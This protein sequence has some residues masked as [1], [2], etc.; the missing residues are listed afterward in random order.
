LLFTPLTRDQVVQAPR[1]STHSL[2]K[3][4]QALP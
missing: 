3:S 4:P 2:A 1:F